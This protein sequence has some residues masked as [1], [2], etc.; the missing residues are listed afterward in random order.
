MLKKRL[1]TADKFYIETNA[2]TMSVEEISKNIQ[3]DISVVRDIVEKKESEDNQK[4][5]K[6]QKTQ[7]ELAFE[8][9]KRPGSVAEKY[10]VTIMS[11]AAS[12]LG[13]KVRK[14]KN[15]SRND[16]IHKPKGE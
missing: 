15:I 9:N 6:K 8:A 3:V 1:N 7:T 10:G 2:N 13:D 4:T 11:P 14:S 16:C 5:E 12:E